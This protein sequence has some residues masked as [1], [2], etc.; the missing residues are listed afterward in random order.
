[1]R[2]QLHSMPYLEWDTSVIYLTPGI[3][4]TLAVTLLLGLDPD[5]S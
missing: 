4:L 5:R 3:P 2:K 1:M